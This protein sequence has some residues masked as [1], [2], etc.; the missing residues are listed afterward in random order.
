M[1]SK[2]NFKIDLFGKLHGMS[3]EEIEIMKNDSE[4]SSK[5]GKILKEIYETFNELDAYY[6]GHDNHVNPRMKV[7]DGIND[8]LNHLD[9]LVTN[10]L[11]SDIKYASLRLVLIL[12]MYPETI[13]QVQGEYIFYRRIIHWAQ[14]IYVW[15]LNQ[16][17][18]N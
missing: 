14:K 15:N 16:D 7:T 5:E 10:L 3:E 9:E 13:K 8:T 18:N 12:N 6:K 2:N 11:K 1:D 4:E 17:I